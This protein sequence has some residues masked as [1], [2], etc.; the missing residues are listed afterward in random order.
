MKDE[1][2]RL[3]EKVKTQYQEAAEIC[4]ECINAWVQLFNEPSRALSFYETF[5]LDEYTQKHEGWIS[6]DDKDKLENF[7]SDLEPHDETSEILD[8]LS[9]FFGEEHNELRADIELKASQMW[10]DVYELLENNT[11]LEASESKSSGPMAKR[12]RTEE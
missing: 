12:L 11:D 9:S 7:F 1:Y 10:E 5:E 3:S 2:S 4:W 6:K 8:Y